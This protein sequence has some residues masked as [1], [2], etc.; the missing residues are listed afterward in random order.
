MVKTKLPRWLRIIVTLM[1]VLLLING[2]VSLP[3][4]LKSRLD[5]L[6]ASQTFDFTT[7]EFKTLTRKVI[8]RLLS[9][10]RLLDDETQIEFVL[11]YLS[12]V[13]ETQHLSSEI[14]RI[15]TD[16][17]VT[18]PAFSSVD[19]RQSLEL[20]RSR[21]DVEGPIAE[22]ILEDQ[23][24]SVLRSGGF[25]PLISVF[26]PVRGI[27]TPLPYILI[28]SPRDTIESIYQQQLIV[29]LT[30]AQQEQIEN[31]VMDEFSDYSAYVTAIGGL[32][33]YPAML[34]ESSSIDWVA[35]VIAHEWVHHNLAFYP[36]GWNYLKSDEA[37]TMN[38]TTASLVGDWAG[39]EVIST[40]YAINLNRTKSLPNALHVTEEEE[41]A[42]GQDFDFRAEMHRTRINVDRLLEE[43]KINEA[44]WYM[45]FQ[46]RFFVEKGYR[47]RLLN[48]AYFAFHGAYADVQ[49][50]SGRDPI[51]PLIR[52]LWGLSQS[53]RAFVKKLAPLTS[54][55]DLEL[56][57][58]SGLTR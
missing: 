51:G 19:L 11:D 10:H 20:L 31:Q 43:G 34:L 45:E 53:P 27:F 16:P 9:P 37:R 54:L 39:Q 2:E 42:A 30:A 6:T 1:G 12:D 33:A 24:S 52:R 32:A 23:V 38:E 41:Q 40:Y 29:G 35:D 56:L 5:R 58:E 26:P 25:G 17:S 28:V 22:A 36:L 55:A 8:Y 50:A 3:V 21:M 13:R 18:D 48:Q 14:E 15:Y 44:E 57:L 7:W 46:R 4:D 47:I 49:G